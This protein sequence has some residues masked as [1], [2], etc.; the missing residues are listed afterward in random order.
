MGKTE[1]EQLQKRLDEIRSQELKQII[2]K[3]YP[4]FEA[5][6]GKTFKKRNCNSLPKKPSDYWWLYSK[7]ISINKDDIYLGG[8]YKDQLEECPVLA[9]CEVLRFQKDKNGKVI[10]GIE[11]TY[12]HNLGKEIPLKNFNKAY[13]DIQNFISNLNK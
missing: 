5:L 2:D 12:V 9:N 4:E 10:V 8:G 6:I 1:K 11:R 7:I 3:A 13:A